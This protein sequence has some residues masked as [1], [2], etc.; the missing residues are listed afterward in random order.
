MNGMARER[1][2]LSQS[3]IRGN[4]QRDGNNSPFK[5]TDYGELPIR[6]TPQKDFDRVFTYGRALSSALEP[7]LSA[8]KYSNGTRTPNGKDHPV[9]EAESQHYQEATN[10]RGSLMSIEQTAEMRSRYYQNELNE[11]GGYRTLVHQEQPT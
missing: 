4:Y 3:P 9:E 8:K 10:K 7:V 1:V 2:N 6:A 11:N 5:A